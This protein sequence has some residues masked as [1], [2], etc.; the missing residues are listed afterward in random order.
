MTSLTA[1]LFT[2]LCCDSQTLVNMSSDGSL[3]IEVQ[4]C[5]E[6][7]SDSSE[8][9][10]EFEDEEA[11]LSR[12]NPLPFSEAATNSSNHDTSCGARA[13]SDEPLADAEW[14]QEYRERKE[15]VEE[16]RQILEKRLHGITKVKEWYAFVVLY[17]SYFQLTVYLTVQA[18]VTNSIFEF[19][20]KFS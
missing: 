15:T 13:Y 18:L 17:K 2:I 14:L 8:N 7:S 1:K 12:E 20:S 19:M 3:E 16:Q 5:S 9:S 6:E 11:E 4:N 10:F